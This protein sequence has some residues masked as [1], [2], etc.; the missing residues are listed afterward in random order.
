[1]KKRFTQS[2]PVLLAAVALFGVA[3]PV[4]AQ[5]RPPVHDRGWDAHERGARDWHR[6]HPVVERGVV[7]APPAVV[8]AP[9]PQP[10]GINLIL[11]L[12]FR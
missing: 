9:P 4:A 3:A 5:A 6:H 1:M 2:L 12:H 7:Y 8:E 10:E 11:P